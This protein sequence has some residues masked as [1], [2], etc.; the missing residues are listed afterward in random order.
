MDTIDPT[1]P[2]KLILEPRRG[3]QALNLNSG[4]TASCSGSS[5]GAMSQQTLLGATWAVI[6]PL[7]SPHGEGV[8]G[9]GLATSPNRPHAK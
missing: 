9:R 7:L 8:R 6:Q 2:E 4:A 3:W 5:P 1:A